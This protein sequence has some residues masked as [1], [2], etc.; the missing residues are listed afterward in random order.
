M[1]F[2]INWFV[3]NRII[4]AK[5]VSTMTIEELSVASN[6]VIKMIEERDA[7]LVHILSDES[8][9]DSFPI[10]VKALREVVGFMRHQ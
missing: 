7:P 9:L 8:D 2:D 6:K 1:P 3:E 10:S 4:F 5:A